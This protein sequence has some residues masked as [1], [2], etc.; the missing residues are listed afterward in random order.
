MVKCFLKYII[1][2]KNKI[3]GDRYVFYGHKKLYLYVSS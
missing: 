1:E 2:H 3:K